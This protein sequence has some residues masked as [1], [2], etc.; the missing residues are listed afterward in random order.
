MRSYFNSLVNQYPFQNKISVFE[1]KYI[2]NSMFLKMDTD[3]LIFKYPL[4]NW[5]A[6]IIN[7]KCV[8]LL[9]LINIP[10]YVFM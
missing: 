10:Q 7:H 3:Q 2:K 8:P 4:E 5:L 1:N 6:Y 9:S